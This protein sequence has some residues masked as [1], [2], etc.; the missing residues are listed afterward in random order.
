[1]LYLHCLGTKRRLRRRRP[2]VYSARKDGRFDSQDH[3]HADISYRWPNE[4]RTKQQVKDL[5]DAVHRSILSAFE[6]PLP[7]CPEIANGALGAPDRGRV[8]AYIPGNTAALYG[9]GRS[10]SPSVGLSVDRRYT[11]KV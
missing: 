9:P 11:S 5:L 2:G 8:M 3:Q 4:V 10:H 1:M 6:V 7:E